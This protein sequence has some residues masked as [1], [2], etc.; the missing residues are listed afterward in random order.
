MRTSKSVCRLFSR[1]VGRSEEPLSVLRK[2]SSKAAIV[3]VHGYR[4]SARGTWGDFGRLIT[5][6]SGLEGW[7]VYAVDY[8]TGLCPDMLR[9]LWSADAPL[10]RLSKRLKT[11]MRSSLSQYDSLT[12]IAHS[13]GGLIVQRTLLDGGVLKR[14]GHI[15]LFGTPSGGTEKARYFR[16]S[17]RQIR[18]MAPDSA[19]IKK[20][21]REWGEYFGV[22][23]SF[24]SNFDL[25]VV[26]GSEDEF[27][28]VTSSLDPFPECVQYVV[29][30]NHVEMVRPTCVD[31]PSF[32]LVLE[33]LAG[34]KSDPFDGARLAVEK[35]RFQEAVRRFENHASELDASALV[36]YAIALD[37]IDQREEAI[38]VLESHGKSETDAIGTL[39]GRYKRQWKLE[40][41]A[42]DGSKALSLY[43]DAYNRASSAEQQYYHSINIAFMQFVFVKNQ[44]EAR[45]WANRALLH[46]DDA[47]RGK[48]CFA[49]MGEANLILRNS[50][51][52]LE[53]YERVLKYRPELWEVRSMYEQAVY[54]AEAAELPWLKEELE[55]TFTNND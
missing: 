34:G 30:G 42:E 46:C 52:A 6:H 35:K 32:Q 12:V 14:V 41:R 19:F 4:G 10:D 33:K 16:F 20:L 36:Q 18:D 24:S 39:A 45:S 55:R 50:Q 29:P 5:Q 17:K 25:H 1:L 43:Q 49:T 51:R 9:R 31:H 26:A 11:T 23:D 40:R 15:F 21:R 27:V 47:P 13:M 8:A 28:P 48:W 54:V 38:Q 37:N 44:A 22:E 7:D 53:N 2:T 3:L